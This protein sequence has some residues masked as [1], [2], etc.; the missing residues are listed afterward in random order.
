[1][2]EQV[3][4]MNKGLS[5]YKSSLCQSSLQIILMTRAILCVVMIQIYPES[6]GK[7][8]LIVECQNDVLSDN[9]DTY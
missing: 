1:M 8:I 2:S 6:R 4:F 9:K 3:L 7:L 5:L